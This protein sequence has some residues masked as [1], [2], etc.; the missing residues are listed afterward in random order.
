V[1]RPQSSRWPVTLFFLALL[2][3]WVIELGPMRMSLYRFVLVGMIGP[4]IWKWARGD[5][6]PIRVTDLAL[7]GYC[8]WCSMSIIV[9]HGPAYAVQPAGILWIETMGSY[10]LGRCFIRSAD[11][12]FRVV[13]FL[14]RIVVALLPFALFEALTGRNILLELFAAVGPTMRDNYMEPRWGMRRVQSVFEHPILFGVFCAS[15]FAL[16]HNVLGYGKSFVG[17]WARSVPVAFAALL[18]LSAGPITALF[19]Q[20]MLLG[21]N[22]ALRGF[23]GRWKLLMSAGALAYFPLELLS[24]RS[25]PVIF[26]SIFAFDEASARVRVDI[27]GYGSAS[28]LKHPLFGLGFNDWVRAPWMSSSIDMFWIID[29][30]RHGI[31]AELLMATAFFAVFLSVAFHKVSDERIESYRL[32]YL[33]TMMGFFLAGWTVYFWNATYV[34]FMFLLGA[35][36]WILDT[37]ASSGRANGKPSASRNPSQRNPRVVR[38]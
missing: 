28:A 37:G 1:S 2:V 8:F 27:W 26:I 15:I 17:R 32:G 11:D 35:G 6:G 38:R 9:I 5:A 36:A 3:P 33:I 29:A 31:P 18:S 23:A 14:F 19:G 30:V 12:F 10:L 24:N 4:C 16:T 21:W 20:V 13:Q 7:I 25:V 34:C 22:W